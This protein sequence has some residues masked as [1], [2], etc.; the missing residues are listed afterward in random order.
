M[1]VRRGPEATLGG[2]PKLEWGVDPAVYRMRAALAADHRGVEVGDSAASLAE[3]DEQLTT[4]SKAHVEPLAEDADV[5][6]THRRA[7]LGREERRDRKGGRIQN[8]EKLRGRRVGLHAKVVEVDDRKLDR[9]A[10][11]VGRRKHLAR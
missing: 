5:A 6:A 3:V 1:K 4:A 11:H 7:V 9:N 2:A 8:G 10:R